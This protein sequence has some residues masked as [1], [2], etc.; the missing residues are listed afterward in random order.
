MG[1]NEQKQ[2][3]SDHGRLFKFYLRYVG[4]IFCLFANEHQVPTFL[5]FSNSQHPNLNFIIEIEDKKQLPFLDVL[6]TC[7]ET[8]ITNIYGKNTFTGLFQ[9]YNSFLP[10]TFKEGLV[11][12]LIDVIFRLNNTLDGFHLD[13]QKLKVIFTR[14]RIPT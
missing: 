6:S 12:T 5:D 9:N 2:L 7:S 8:L 4:D 14:K 10:F 3:E 11:K 13:L 1:Y